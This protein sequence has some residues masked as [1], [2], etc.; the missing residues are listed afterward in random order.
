MI[1][2]VQS[3]LRQRENLGW[4][5]HCFVNDLVEFPSRKKIKA[6]YEGMTARECQGVPGNARKY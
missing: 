1:R 3:S 2:C 5:Q 6:I 4:E